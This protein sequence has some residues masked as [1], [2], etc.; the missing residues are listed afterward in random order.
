MTAIAIDLDAGL[1]RIVKRT[2]A[3]RERLRKSWRLLAPIAACVD[4]AAKGAYHLYR[5]H[6]YYTTLK[7]LNIALVNTQ[8][9]FKTE[10]VLG[11]PYT[12]KIES[13]NICNTKCQLCPT[14]IG[15]E[16]R[17]KGKMQ[18]EQYKKLVD[19]LK[20][21]LVALD[22]SMWGDPLI[23]PDIHNMIR[24]AHDRG[25]WTYISS[26]LH[27]FKIKPK[28]GET[29]DQ[30]TRLVESGLDLMTCSLH[31]ATQETF[32]IY[33]PGKSLADGIEKI[34]H[35]IRTRD[36]MG[37]RTPFV[38]LNFVVTKYNQHERDAFQKLADELGCKAV[39]STPSLN[40]RFKD[41]DEKLV[42]LGL[43]KDLLEQRVRSHIQKWLP[44]EDEFA[45]EPYRDIL[46]GKP[47]EP[48]H[49]NGNKTFNCDW[50]WR[51]SVINW[52]GEVAVCCGSFAPE[53]DMGNVFE[54]GFAK[55]WNGPVY[56]AARR[57]FTK[58]VNATDAKDN[59]CTTCPGFML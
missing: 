11:R 18:T 15:L 56:R 42:P 40:I 53:E 2:G 50:P 5:N 9:Y 10:R 27:A 45:L 41:R 49:F 46:D 43:D 23:V 14:G 54:H 55:V 26:N 21:H 52:D 7:L 51:Q 24:Y 58:R 38:Q 31:A 37:S 25:I 4:I 3:W 57:S 17:P 28:K 8:F 44:E 13:T 47:L 19:E 29:K 20:W 59:P 36:A 39:F 6:R 32:A 1:A 34:R 48:D 30:A 35:I 16:G 33:Q 22:L 12:M